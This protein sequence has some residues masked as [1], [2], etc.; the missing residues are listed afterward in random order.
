VGSDHRSVVFPHVCIVTRSVAA[1]SSSVN[2]LQKGKAF[3]DLKDLLQEG[4]KEP[5]DQCTLQYCREKLR[6]TDVEKAAWMDEDGGGYSY[7]SLGFSKLANTNGK[8][9]RVE[10]SFTPLDTGVCQSVTLILR[11]AIS[12]SVCVATSGNDT[13]FLS[14]KPVGDISELENE[15]YEL[16]RVPEG[17]TGIHDIYHA[18]HLKVDSLSFV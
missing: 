2:E 9:P 12:G 11:G 16:E 17:K 1:K 10:L 14:G 15:R 3:E 6:E 18:C 8:V 4:L 5:W 7:S 13:W